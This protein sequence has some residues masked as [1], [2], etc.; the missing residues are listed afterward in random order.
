MKTNFDEVLSK[1]T[2]FLKTEAHTETVVGKEFKDV[3]GLAN[4]LHD[5][6]QVTSC[7]VKRVFAYGTGSPASADEKATLDYLNKT[8]AA[9]GYRLRG[10]LKTV[11]MSS[12]FSTVATPTPEP[13]KTASVVFGASGASHVKSDAQ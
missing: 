6:P 8:F 2:D 7:L 9:N 10:L 12:A 4:A 11:V 5:H 1:V 13:A 3:T